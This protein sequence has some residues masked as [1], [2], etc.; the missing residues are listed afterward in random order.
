V[1]KEVRLYGLVFA[2][3][4]LYAIGWIAL[5]LAQADT[6]LADDSFEL[7]AGMYGLF[8]TLLVGAISI[9][10]ER[11][12]GTADTQFLQ[13][14]P[15]WKQWLTKLATVG[16]ISLLVGLAV[17]R[18]LE[19]VLPLIDSSKP[20]G[21]D[22]GYL[23]YLLPNLLN[24]PVAT[25]LLLALFSCYVSTMCVGGL[26]ALLVALPSS[27]TLA[28]LYG[29]LMVG[30]YRLERAVTTSLYGPSR[31]CQPGVSV[32]VCERPWYE[33]LPT[34]DFNTDFMPP[35]TYDRWM[36]TIA[37]VGFAA[38]TLFLYRRNFRSGERG[39]TMA[40]KQLPWV[41]MYV[42]LAT[43]LTRGGEGVLR[44]WLLTH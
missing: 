39:M 11:A 9:A 5:W 38:L 30:L 40:R 33:G 27:F 29:G 23:R 44:V 24:G 42:A 4:G 1:Q 19:A 16:L 21:P 17:P 8:I 26:R 37:F 22:L 41:A 20:V 36:T 6:Y 3:A 10:E 25:L 31:P 18:S 2:L 35:Y 43:V 12:L 14:W 28:S 15:F 13:P 7:Y 34:V 32:D